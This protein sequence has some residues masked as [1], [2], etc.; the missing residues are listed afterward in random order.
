MHGKDILLPKLSV[1]VEIDFGV[2]AKDAVVIRLDEGV[3][4]NLKYCQNMHFI[5]KIRRGDNNPKT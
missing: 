1:V 3:D 5:S 2:N 4:L